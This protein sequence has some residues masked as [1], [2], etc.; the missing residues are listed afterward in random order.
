M[1]AAIVTDNL[2]VVH[3]GGHRDLHK[4]HNK[5]SNGWQSK[6]DMFK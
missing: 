4:H 1:I 6:N 2:T 5:A 3:I